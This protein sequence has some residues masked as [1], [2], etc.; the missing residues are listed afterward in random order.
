MVK[1]PC[2]PKLASGCKKCIRECFNI[3]TVALNAL[4]S[5]GQDGSEEAVKLG[6]YSLTIL[7][8]FLYQ[9]QFRW[10][11]FE[12]NDTD[13]SISIMMISNHLK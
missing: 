3:K 4:P 8:T 10:L 6:D 7:L 1:P 9:F 12:G 11:K 5:G 13:F 2:G